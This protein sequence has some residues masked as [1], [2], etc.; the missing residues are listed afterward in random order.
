MF[1]VNIPPL[2]DVKRTSRSRIPTL[3]DADIRERLSDKNK[4]LSLVV[5]Y[6]KVPPMAVIKPG[7]TSKIIAGASN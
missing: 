1:T 3:R 6:I 5:L 7:N 4:E 2:F